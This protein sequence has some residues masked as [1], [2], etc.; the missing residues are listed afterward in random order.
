MRK[1]FYQRIILPG[2]MLFSLSTLMFL[3]GFLCHEYRLFPFNHLREARLASAALIE[4]A[5]IP[6]VNVPQDYRTKVDKPTAI[7]H[8]PTSSSSLFVVS[9]GNKMRLPGSD[10]P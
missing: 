9:A 1:N 7:Q 5:E 3:Y 10:Q 6:S 8:G 2:L 4:I